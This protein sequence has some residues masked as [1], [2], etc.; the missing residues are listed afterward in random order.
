MSALLYITI[1]V[2]QAIGRKS[3]LTAGGGGGWI[4][5]SLE[6]CSRSGAMAIAHHVRSLGVSLHGPFLRRLVSWTNQCSSIDY[7]SLP[8]DKFIWRKRSVNIRRKTNVPC[9]PVML[10]HFL[11]PLGNY[12]RRAIFPEMCKINQSSLDFH[13]KPLWSLWLDWFIGFVLP[14]LFLRGRG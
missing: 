9:Y 13:C 8:R 2:T 10:N 11:H 4:V 14:N 12:T 1:K 7:P 5:P 6:G 3:D